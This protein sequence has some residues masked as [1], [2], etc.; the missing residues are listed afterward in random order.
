MQIN[1]SSPQNNASQARRRA[2]WISAGIIALILAIVIVLV[3]SSHHATPGF[4]QADQEQSTVFEGMSSFIDSGLTTDQVNELTSDF[5]KFSPKAKIVSVDT[6]S[7]STAPHNPHSSDPSFKI[8]F[9]AT[10]DSTPYKGTVKYSGLYTVN[11]FLYK[12]T[13]QQVF[14]SSAAH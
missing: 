1:T 13:G 5:S 12:T 7:L 10:V 4:P 14:D 11:L 6:S 8:N 2:I 9:R 3:S